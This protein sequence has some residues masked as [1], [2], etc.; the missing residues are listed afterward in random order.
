LCWSKNFVIFP[1][2]SV[3]SGVDF[4]LDRV[5]LEG[6]GGGLLFGHGTKKGSLIRTFIRGVLCFG[7]RRR[8]WN[9][10]IEAKKE[11]QLLKRAVVVKQK[12]ERLR[13]LDANC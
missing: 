6:F 2:N 13:P 4:Y 11:W 12:K 5:F 9:E 8:H 3:K 10:M 7:K 1:S